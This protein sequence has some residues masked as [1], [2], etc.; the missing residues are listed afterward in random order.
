[1]NM[2]NERL[3]IIIDSIRTDNNALVEQHR[4]VCLECEHR[5][6]RV[7]SRIQCSLCGCQDPAQT[8]AFCPDIPA[9][10]GREAKKVN[11]QRR[12]ESSQQADSG[13]KPNTSV[14]IASCQEGDWLTKTCDSIMAAKPD[15]QELI[16]VDDASEPPEPVSTIRNSH[17]EG[18]ARSRNLGCARA[19]GDGVLL[20]DAHM[21]IQ[22]GQIE[23]VTNVA[24]ETG[25]I[26]YGGCNGHYCAR[27]AVE[28]GLY[29]VKWMPKT[30]QPL[31]RTTAIM[32]AFYVI[33]REVLEDLGGWIALPGL[34]GM[35]EE[36]MSIL[37]IKHD[38]PITAVTTVQTWHWFR[39]PKDVPY[40]NPSSRY[41]VNVAAMYRLLFDDPAWEMFKKRLVSFRWDDIPM[42]ISGNL[43]RE[44]ESSALVEYG[45]ELRARCRLTDDEFF[46]VVSPNV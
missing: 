8:R 33:P 44:V 28:D 26:A 13:K 30:D 20:M 9:R 45:K 31:I 16:V 2:L 46:R 11:F 40:A 42:S 3:T 14:V 35:D 39:E 5:D 38:I 15:L 24:L 12:L 18:V 7:T 32:G 25:G 10:W 29:R 41:L 21:L 6:L 22:P 27:L 37:A 36:A 4:S 1:M 17:R 34:W 23:E 43:I 19:K